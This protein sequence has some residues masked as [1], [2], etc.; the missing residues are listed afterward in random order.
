M[1]YQQGDRVRISPRCKH[2][3]PAILPWLVKHAGQEA[4]VLNNYGN[5]SY[6]V[7]APDGTT[8]Y[9]VWGLDL[10]GIPH[11]AT[12]NDRT[13]SNPASTTPAGAPAT[14]PAGRQQVRQQKA[15]P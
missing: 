6:D 2:Y 4:R 15:A 3:C 7:I 14:L 12:E 8:G 11:H 5:V 9:L 10:T 1:P 13:A